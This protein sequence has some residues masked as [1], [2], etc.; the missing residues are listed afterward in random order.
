MGDILQ[1]ICECGFKS[2]NL[3]LGGGFL[4]MGELCNAPYYCDN[5]ETIG[6]VNIN[7]IIKCEKC[8]KSVQYYGEIGKD[9]FE[10][11]EDVIFDWSVNHTTR[12]FLKDKFYYCPKCKKINLKFIPIGNWD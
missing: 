7:K 12:Y 1:A 3:Y 9:D 6:T 4:D 8:S 2:N 11:P 5:C 10:I